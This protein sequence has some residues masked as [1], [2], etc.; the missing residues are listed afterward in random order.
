[1]YHP[2]D[3][4]PRTANTRGCSL[5]S[6][7]AQHLEQEESAAVIHRSALWGGRGGKVCRVQNQLAEQLLKQS[8][9]GFFSQTSSS[10][11]ASDK[12]YSALC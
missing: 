8:K 3:F 1:M 2:R 7:A 6:A 5:S 9:H 4:Q 11:S 10:L 12:G